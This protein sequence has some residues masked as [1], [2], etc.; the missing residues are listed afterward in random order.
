MTNAAEL[1][2]GL[3]GRPNVVG[4]EPCITRLRVQ[5]V[6][7]ALVDDDKLQAGGAIGVV[8]SGRV[9]QVIVGPLADAVAAEMDQ[10]P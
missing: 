5:V 10:L 9:I 4:L 2:E 8:R 3:G 6:D 1:L 7:P